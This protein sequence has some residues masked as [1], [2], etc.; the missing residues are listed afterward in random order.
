VNHNAHLSNKIDFLVKQKEFHKISVIYS[1]KKQF[2]K[3]AE[4]VEIDG[5][6]YDEDE[7]GDMIVVESPSQPEPKEP[8]SYVA[9]QYGITFM[10][11]EEYTNWYG[12]YRVLSINDD[13]TMTVEYLQ[14]FKSEIKAGDIKTYPII[15]QAQSISKARRSK[16]IEMKLNNI[17]SLAGSD[18]SFL[19]GLIAAHGYISAEIGPKYHE[20]FPEKYKSVTGEDVNTYLGKGYTLSDNDKRW[21]Y[22]LRVHLPSLPSGLLNRMDVKN[23]INRASGAEINDNSLVWGLLNSGFSVGRNDQKI[24][25]ITANLSDEDKEAFLAGYNILN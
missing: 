10:E 21:S 4:A 1:M 11:G 13:G 24:D 8:K 6:W 19:M 22:T 18:D 25:T 5:K 12:S 17:R 2:T 3:T 7:S 9:D 14:S 15:S 23:I 20:S 16:E